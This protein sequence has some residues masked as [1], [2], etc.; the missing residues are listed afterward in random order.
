M[1]PWFQADN[2]LQGR[3]GSG[4][5]Y[6]MREALLLVSRQSSAVTNVSPEVREQSPEIELSPLTLAGS[7]VVALQQGKYSVSIVYP[8]RKCLD[9]CATACVPRGS[10]LSLLWVVSIMVAGAGDCIGGET[11]V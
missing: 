1:T 8:A 9:Q 4:D 5:W 7:S 11:P 3:G 2:I 6:E 10:V